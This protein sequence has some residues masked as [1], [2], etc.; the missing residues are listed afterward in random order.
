MKQV[1]HYVSA[2]EN[3]KQMIDLMPRWYESRPVQIL[4]AVGLSATAAFAQAG[5]I[6]TSEETNLENTILKW[7][8]GAF[9][10]AM[11]CLFL[12]GC[13]KLGGRDR[14]TGIA[15]MV[16]CG[17]GALAGGLAFVYVSKLTGTNV[18]ASGVSGLLMF[19]TQLLGPDLPGLI[20]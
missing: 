13:T 2:K 3:S 9:A 15:M 12:Y 1:G 18:T 14:G 4:T 10:V 7:V 5:T 19:P 6:D 17:F 8:T 11:V 20:R 16:G